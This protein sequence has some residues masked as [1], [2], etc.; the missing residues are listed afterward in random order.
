ML[1]QNIGNWD[2]TALQLLWKLK[3]NI[4]LNTYYSFCVLISNFFVKEM[5]FFFVCVYK[6]LR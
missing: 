5:E 3:I 6:G 4:H 1:Q 2:F